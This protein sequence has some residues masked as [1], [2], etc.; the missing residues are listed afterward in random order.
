MI[1]VGSLIALTFVASLI[2]TWLMR[3]VSMSLGLIDKPNPR[4]SH[5]VPT[6]RGGGAAIVLSSLAVM[7]IMAADGIV[8]LRLF[9][10]LFGGGLAVATTGFLDDYRT[11]SPRTRLAIHLV[12]AA[13][14][15][16]WV[17]SGDTVLLGGHFDLQKVLGGIVSTVGIAFFLNI[18]NFMD[19]IDGI[20]ASE[21]LL[22][23]G[24]AAFLGGYLGGFGLAAVA[25]VL[26]AAAAG[27]LVWNWP[28]ARI[29]MGDVGSGYIGFVLGVL[30][31]Y[32]TQFGVEKIWTW[33]IL[34][35]IFVVDPMITL[36]RRLWR[37]EA[38]A[39][40]HRMHAYQHA[41]GR[42]GHAR[43]TAAVIII[44]LAW[45]LPL[46]VV[47]V[48]RPDYGL[49]I[50]FFAIVPIACLAVVLGAGSSGTLGELPL[51]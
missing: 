6:P 23:C 30:A 33:L 42:F 27:F 31:L 8:G 24:S 22:V 3:V 17:E 19:G 1:W 44:D 25:L 21:A 36:M 29:F 16:Y 49:P 10:A 18:F 40:A 37:R 11:L 32:G 50:A 20:A 26:A 4:S 5:A 46:A 15:V 48:L 45:L 41:A 38:V 12:A 9:V 47:T 34:G 14:A 39:T 35:A 43:V 13:W 51:P 2:F 7:G 28:P